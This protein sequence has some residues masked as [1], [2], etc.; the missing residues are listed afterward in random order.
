MPYKVMSYN[1][2]PIVDLH[3]CQCSRLYQ[4]DTKIIMEM[5]W[6]EIL[7]EHPENPYDKAHQSDT[8]RIVF[9]EPILLETVLPDGKTPKMPDEKLDLNDLEILCYHEDDRIHNRY[10]YAAIDALDAE[11]H[12]VRIEFLF[13][14]SVVM[15]NT[16]HEESWFEQPVWQPEISDAEILKMLSWN[17]PDAV[18]QKGMALASE[19][20]YLGLFFMPFVGEDSKSLWQNCAVILSKKTDAQLTPWLLQCFFWL[21][22][23]N[24]PGAVIIADRLSAYADKQKL[25]HEKQKA[26]KIAEVLK[27]SEWLEWLNKYI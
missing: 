14:K 22:D 1:T 2:T 3:D 4:K 13:T 5:E 24:W 11:H 26:V 19:I 21:Q 25:Q 12:F 18:Q 7:A 23:M 15:W 20:K 8:G 17:N 27:D 16:L 9:H 6:M 10:K